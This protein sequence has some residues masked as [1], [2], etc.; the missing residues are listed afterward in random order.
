MPIFDP[1]AYDLNRP[2]LA[3]LP[4]AEALL[5]RALL[6]VPSEAR[7]VLWHGLRNAVEGALDLWERTPPG[8]RHA[9]HVFTIQHAGRPQFDDAML[10]QQTLEGW[11]RLAG[12]ELRLTAEVLEALIWENTPV[13]REMLGEQCARVGQLYC[14]LARRAGVGVALSVL[15]GELRLLRHRASPLLVALIYA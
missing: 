7:G 5:G 6:S 1:Y 10:R 12:V 2:A 9:P 13:H 14:E 15:K 8:A 11:H 3:A 4:P